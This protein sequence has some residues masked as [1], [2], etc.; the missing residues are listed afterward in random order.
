MLVA[1]GGL[2]S[3]VRIVMEERIIQW[4]YSPYCLEPATDRPFL[5]NREGALLC[6]EF[7]DGAIG[8]A[9]CHP[10]TSCGDLPLQEQ[11]SRLIDGKMTSLLR[12]SLT[13]ARLDAVAR[14]AGISLLRD[15]PRLSNHW[16]STDP[17]D[18]ESASAEG[19]TLFKIK[20]VE[21]LQDYFEALPSTGKLRID[22]NSQFTRHEFEHFLRDNRHRLKKVDFFEDPFPYDDEDWKDIQR[23]YGVN[24]ACDRHSEKAFGKAESAK[25]VIIKPAAQ[26]IV[27]APKEQHVV[28]TS[29]L[30][31]P[32]GQASAAYVAALIKCERPCGLNSHRTYK[33]T[34]FSEQLSSFGNHFT[35]APGPGF[36]FHEILQK[37][38]WETIPKPLYC[39]NKI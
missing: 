8:Y 29:Y 18:I 17:S 39:P 24:L 32:L 34:A 36:G 37:L 23:T 20:G 27:E 4:S 26:G 16:L 21:Q 15:L 6:I 38:A 19:Y 30:D 12:A 2:R 22:L 7:E 9:D 13:F 14:K 10:W 31:H 35:A 5:Q 28:V 3:Y 11:L 33:P 1:H 25:T